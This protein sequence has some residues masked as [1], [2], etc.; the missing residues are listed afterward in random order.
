M[1]VVWAFCGVLCVCFGALGVFLPLLPTVPFMLLAAFCF[2]RSSPQL[3]DWLLSH[4]VFGT[5]IMDWQERGAISRRGK[6][7]ATLSIAAVFVLSLALGV[8]MAILGVQAAVL[9]GVLTFI[10]TRPAS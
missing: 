6:I 7:A 1:R 2:A 8:R 9:I 10:W 4:P 3:H 5:P